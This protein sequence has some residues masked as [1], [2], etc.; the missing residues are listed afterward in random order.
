MDFELS[1]SLDEADSTAVAGAG[2]SADP[3]GSSD[4]ETPKELDAPC[5]LVA[6]SEN[7]LVSV[8]FSSDWEAVTTPDATFLG[9]D[10]AACAA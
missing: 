2:N 1:A 5:S 10:L 9:V 4:H 8:R 3:K 6:D 7:M